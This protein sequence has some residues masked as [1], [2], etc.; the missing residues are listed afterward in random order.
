M[1]K[2]TASVCSLKYT[3]ILCR[4]CCYGR[5]IVGFVVYNKFNV[6]IGTYGVKLKF[7]DLYN[8]IYLHFMLRISQELQ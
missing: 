1:W 3:T 5:C 6:H 2:G 8:G 4:M 7:S